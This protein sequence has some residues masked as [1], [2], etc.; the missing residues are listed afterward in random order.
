MITFIQMPSVPFDWMV[1]RP[2]QIMSKLA[3]DGYKVYYFN[4]K[5]AKGI[6]QREPNLNIVG[7]NYNP[8]D[9]KGEGSV[10]LWCSSPEQVVNIDKIPHDYIVYDVVDD[11]SNEFI[12]WAPY[13]DTMLER[14]DIVFTTADRLYEKFKKLHP[15]VYLLNN[16]VNLDN[17][18]LNKIEKPK[19]LPTFRPIVGYVGAVANWID[20]NLVEC[21]TKKSRYNFVFVGPFYNRFKPSL[22]RSNIYY[23]GVKNYNELPYY[24]NN[25]NCCIIPFK[26]NDMT[27]SCN[28][29][30]LYEYFSLGKP[31]ITTSM[32]EIYNFSDLCYIANNPGEFKQC[33]DKAIN[34]RS[35]EM[36]NKRIITAQQN[37]WDSRINMIKK[38]LNDEFHIS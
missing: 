11:A 27:N 9:I 15:R 16:A 34:E 37:G 19:D 24:I 4:N 3:K 23:L 28:P 17:F 2:Q 36:T 20:W 5:E 13:I 33:I 12:G 35:N 30:K 8:S 6:V 25:F 21:I 31:V 32:K 29:V 18:S 14:A 38:I 22:I 7:S 1:Q 26:V 10:V